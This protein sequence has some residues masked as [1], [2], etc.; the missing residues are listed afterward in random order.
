M[1]PPES[2]IVA[3]EENMDQHPE[4][5]KLRQ[6][7]A[8]NEKISVIVYVATNPLSVR[9]T[10]GAMEYGHKGLSETWLGLNPAWKRQMIKTVERLSIVQMRDK[11][12]KCKQ[13]HKYIRELR[14]A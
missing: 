5:W 9:L 7:S 6:Y 3:I 4:D 14:N 2:V 11:I 10:V 13:S 12:E 1:N 8:E